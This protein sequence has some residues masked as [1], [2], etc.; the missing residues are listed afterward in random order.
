[1]GMSRVSKTVVICLVAMVVVFVASIYVFKRF[2]AP[3]KLVPPDS[4]TIS[5]YPA[6]PRGTKFDS[7]NMSAVERRAF[8]TADYKIINKVADLP[9]GIKKLYSAK[10]STRV[11]IAGPG[12]RFEATDLITD[13]NLPRRRLIFAGVAQDR[14]FIHYE[15]GGFAHSY[16]VELYRLDSPE[17]AIGLWRGYRGPAKN[18]EELKRM[19]SEE[20]CCQ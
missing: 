7:A 3:G 17:H 8:L 12:E 20:D 13:R 10:G 2:F 16:L 4:T 11:V 1:V 6:P 9:D 18:F 15:Q 19:V 5:E 14:A